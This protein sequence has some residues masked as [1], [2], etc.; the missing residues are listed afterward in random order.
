MQETISELLINVKYFYHDYWR[1]KNEFVDSLPL[2][3]GGPWYVICITLLYIWF[4]TFKGPQMM[5]N[6]PNAFDLRPILLFYN[7][8]MVS[9]NGFIFYKATIFTNF[10]VYPW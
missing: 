6:R 7:L 1:A 2:M 4:S 3:R 9:I 5:K 8:M 10:G